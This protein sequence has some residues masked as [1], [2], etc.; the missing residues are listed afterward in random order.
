VSTIVVQS[1]VLVVL[2]RL[3][4]PEAFG[5]IGQAMIFVGFAQILSEIGMAGAIVQR[6][7]L[8]QGHLRTAFTM[9]LLGGGLLS[10][11]FWAGADL[12]ARVFG[13]KD[14]APLLR[15]LSVSFFFA[16][17]G[18]TRSGLLQRKLDFRGRY[19]MTVVPYLVGYV[20][21]GITLAFLGFGA[22]ALAYATLVEK[23]LTMIL[24]F[25]IT[26]YP[27]RPAFSTRDAK[28]LLGFGT[29][30]SLNTIVWYLTRNTDLFV[31][32]RWLGAADLGFYSRAATVIKAPVTASTMLVDVLFPAY[33]EI[34]DDAKRIRM[35]FTRSVC[36]A[37]LIAYPVLAGMFVAAPELVRGLFGAKWEPTIIV[38]QIQCV[39]A[40]FWCID[41]LA[42]ALAR[43]KG[44]VYALCLRRI[45][46]FLACFAGAFCG[47]PWGI[48]GVALGVAAAMFLSYVMLSHLALRLIEG[49]WKDLVAA[50]WPG[51]ILAAIVAATAYGTAEILRSREY[52]DLVVLAGIMLSC[53]GAVG[54]TAILTPRS[55]LGDGPLWARQKMEILLAQRFSAFQRPAS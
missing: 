10:V 54:A 33:A 39:G 50:Q 47:T 8:T 25:I 28:D 19:W 30:N 43:A 16:N 27:W 38:L 5:L 55:R 36:V 35:A 48:G 4:A 13:E 37:A 49:T 12:L 31:V 46:F 24:L 42:G 44:A 15:V 52:P 20:P 34:Q 21:V 40:M 18:A 9:S 53:G 26:E 32:G 11:A 6:R 2:A 41:S 3:L 7:D 22:W 51:L 14:L 29:G 17:A 1:A 45:V 23:C